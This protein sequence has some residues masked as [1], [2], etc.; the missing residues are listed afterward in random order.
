MPASGS[1]SIP[2]GSHARGCVDPLNDSGASGAEIRIGY[3]GPEGTFSHQA[4][5]LTKE[6]IWAQQNQPAR[7]GLVPS[8]SF[9][10]LLES[11]SAGEVECVVLPLVNSSTGLVDIA[12]EAL[13]P[14]DGSLDAGGIVDVGVSFDVFASNKLIAQKAEIAAG[15]SAY[16]GMNCFSHPQ[17]LSQ[18]AG[19]ILRSGLVPVRATST[20]AACQRAFNEGGLAIAGPLIGEEYNLSL[21]S[22]NV[23]DRRVALTRFLLLGNRGFFKP[24]RL[25]GGNRRS[26]WIVDAKLNAGTL[27]GESGGEIIVGKTGLALVLSSTSE[28]QFEGSHWV[29]GGHF[30]NLPWPPSTPILR[31]TS[32]AGT[33]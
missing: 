6:L 12:A 19:F 30:G 15:M 25:L 29:S 21:L 16:R 23:G 27:E 22:S 10:E 4:A 11:L 13:R 7:P 8:K 2:A 18:C 32:Q 28:V 24:L 20:A 17:A 5:Y 26:L 31:A 1:S 33:S 9:E 3:L 14:R